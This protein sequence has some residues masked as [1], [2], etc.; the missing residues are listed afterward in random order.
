M[1]EEGAS[2]HWSLQKATETTGCLSAIWSPFISFLLHDVQMF[3][4]SVNYRNYR[5]D[6]VHE[7]HYQGGI[8]NHPVNPDFSVTA[9]GCHIFLLKR[10][11]QNLQIPTRLEAGQEPQTFSMTPLRCLS[12]EITLSLNTTDPVQYPGPTVLRLRTMS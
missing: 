3:L 5:K 6:Q 9:L 11:P 10:L 4:K 8:I 12:K 2:T 7:P 1:R